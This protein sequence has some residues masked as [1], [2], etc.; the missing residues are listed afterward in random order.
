[1]GSEY[2]DLLA[3]VLRYSPKKRFTPVQALAH[4]FFDEL[5]DRDVFM[6]LKGEYQVGALFEFGRE[7]SGGVVPEWWR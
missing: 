5:R 4:P 2:Y 7:V 1:M 3:N 6:K